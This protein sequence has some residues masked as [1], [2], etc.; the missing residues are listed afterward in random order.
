M[1]RCTSL[2]FQNATVSL[3]TLRLEP[4]ARHVILS[5]GEKVEVV[6][7]AGPEGPGFRVV[8]AAD[9]TLLYT[10]GCE[11]AWVI[12]DGVSLE[13]QPTYDTLPL[14]ARRPRAEDDPLW[15]PDLDLAR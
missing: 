7:E 13:L 1:S 14:P 15:D 10:S 11:R 6:A 9:S 5:P 3:R 8:E 2:S 4:W 12:Q